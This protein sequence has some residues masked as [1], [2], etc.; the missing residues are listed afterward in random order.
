[1]KTQVKIKAMAVAI[2]I[3]LGASAAVFNGQMAND[4]G[5]SLL[6][7]SAVAAQGEGGQKGRMGGAG[8]GGGGQSLPGGAGSHG[9][10]GGRSAESLVSD[11]A[12]DGDDSDRPDWAMGNKQLNPHSGDPNP[13]PGVTK[14][15]EYGD[16][17]VVVRNPVTGEPIL[18]DGELQV[19]LNDGCTET[20]VTVD[21]EVPEGVVPVEVEFGRLNIGRAPTKVIAHAEDEALSK[22]TSATTLT[23][24]PSGRIVVDGATIDS[25]LENLAIYIAIMTGDAQVLEALSS[26]NVD[27]MAL[28][29]AALGAAA[30]KTG[31]ITVDLLYYSNAIYDLVPAGASYVDYSSFSYDRSIYDQTVSY[32]YTLDG[33]VTYINA[34]V[35]LKDYLTATQPDLG[36]ASGITLFS[37]ASDDALEVVELIH[38]QIH[39]SVLPGTQ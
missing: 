11:E 14:G 1:M 30:D 21:G 24:D 37:I 5:F 13:T 7:P 16:L 34:T 32:V 2:G 25:P 9:Q 8:Y 35:N 26:L 22:I 10:R 31:E 36:G 27:P 6:M 4:E 33:G 28:A 3:V 23:L 18:V 20:V 12:D 17:F 39:T 38:T 15:D 29:A 19:C